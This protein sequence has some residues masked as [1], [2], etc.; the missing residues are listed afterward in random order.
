MVSTRRLKFA[1][2]AALF[3]LVFSA[4]IALAF[5]LAV[6]FVWYPG[7]YAELSG[8]WNL[9]FILVSVDVVCGPLL[10]FVVFSPDKSSQHL[11]RDIACIL[12][13]QLLAL[14]YGLHS[15]M[16]A[17][18]VFLAFE[19]DRFR[20]V[21]LSDVPVE[22]LK[23]IDK[24]YKIP[25]FLGPRPIGVKLSTAGSLDYLESLRLSLSGIPP[26]FRPECWVDYN[27][28]RSVVLRK[29][30]PVSKLERQYPDSLGLINRPI[31]SASLSEGEVGY[32]P[33]SA[34]KQDG[35][36]VLVSL[37]DASPLALLPLS[38]WF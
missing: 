36:V 9:L 37:K 8:G 32:L 10:T 5:A 31:K 11:R 12:L 22:R 30:K 1:T 3:H 16:Q 25:G 34:Y 38:G 13:F 27:S 2:R 29:A 35:W 17:R 28:Q 23:N 19:G 33:L 14:A 15:V 21:A 24:K 18:P 26:A 6:F 4:F 20:V 7:G